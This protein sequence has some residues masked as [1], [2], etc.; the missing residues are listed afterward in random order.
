[1]KQGTDVCVTDRGKPEEK[2]E[3]YEYPIYESTAEFVAAY[4]EEKAL[5]LANGK[6]KTEARNAKALAMK[7]KEP[8]IMTLVKQIREAKKAGAD[9][10]DLLAALFGEPA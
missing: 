4:G 7:G 1:M 8:G 10:T 5:A 6:V 9:V 2:K 3:N